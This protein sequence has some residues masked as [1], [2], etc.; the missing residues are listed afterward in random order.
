MKIDWRKFGICLLGGIAVA[1][2]IPD[3]SRGRDLMLW[4]ALTTTGKILDII[5]RILLNIAV[6]LF[7]AFG[8]YFTFAFYERHAK[9]KKDV[10]HNT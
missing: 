8:M 3:Y 1:I 9:K 10:R 4:G 2:L 6:A 5:V 7:W